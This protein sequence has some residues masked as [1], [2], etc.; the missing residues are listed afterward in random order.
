M[1]TPPTLFMGYGT[2]DFYT[3]IGLGAPLQTLPHN[4]HYKTPGLASAY[5][6]ICHKLEELEQ[7]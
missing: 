1:S 3:R 2:L 7:Q 5:L 4:P 6:S